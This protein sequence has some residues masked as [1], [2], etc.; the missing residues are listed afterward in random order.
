VV[1]PLEQDGCAVTAVQYP[2]ISFTDD[3]MPKK[4]GLCLRDTRM[5]AWS[6]ALLLLENPKRGVM[7]AT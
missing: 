4:E 6:L 1:R 7:A 3:Q 2:F 5:A